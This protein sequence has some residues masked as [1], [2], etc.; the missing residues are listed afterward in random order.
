MIACSVCSLTLAMGLMAAAPAPAPAAEDTVAEARALYNAGNYDAAIQAAT[1]AR[2]R[3]EAANVAALVLARARLERFR[4]E[5]D[6]VDLGEGR[7]ALDAVDPSPLSSRD[8]RE[9]LVGLAELQYFDGRFG[10]AAELFNSVLDDASGADTDDA[11]RERL[12]DWW[13][14]ALDRRAREDPGR[15]DAYPRILD[16]ME[17]ELRERPGS[18]AAAYWIP[19]AAR[20]A[21]DLQRAW[22]AAIAG[23]V[24]ASLTGARA[25]ALRADLDRFVRELLI[26]EFAR[27]TPTRPA[28]DPEALAQEWTAVT[29]GWKKE[30]GSR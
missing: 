3:P 28:R 30:A 12:L 8:R 5:Q 2:R 15:L 14:T 1:I 19:V 16:R 29:G 26:P 6:E 23:W 7:T 25:D 17:A 10:A 18:A 11:A 20:G 27:A 22:D 21:G 9:Y 13:A 4:V 24:R